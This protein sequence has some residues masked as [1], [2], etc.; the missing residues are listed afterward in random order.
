MGRDVGAARCE[1]T[2]VELSS[3]DARGQRLAAPPRA[4]G[5]PAA[6]GAAAGCAAA[7]WRESEQAGKELCLA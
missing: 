1:T 4:A 6:V 3:F 2:E 7:F 5:A